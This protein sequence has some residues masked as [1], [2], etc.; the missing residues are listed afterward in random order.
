[1]QSR[2]RTRER[3]VGTHTRQE[4]GGQETVAGVRTRRCP[5][6]ACLTARKH[7]MDP[8]RDRDGAGGMV[9][10]RAGEGGCSDL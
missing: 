10:G 7:D 1:M 9:G 6:D 5:L 2:A 4:A 3:E 8:V